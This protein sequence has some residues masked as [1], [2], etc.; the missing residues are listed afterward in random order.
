MALMI[1]A[2]GVV[3]S[4]GGRR[5]EHRGVVDCCCDDAGTDPAPAQP[6]SEDGCL[7]RVYTGRGEDDLIRSRSYRGGNHFSGLV[8]GLCRKPAGPVETSRIAPAGLLRIKP[9]LAGISEHRLA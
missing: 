8:H 2:D 5:R 7:T 4:G 6:E 3:H 9:S 1:D